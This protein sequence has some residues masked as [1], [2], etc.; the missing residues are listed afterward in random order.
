MF[1]VI[2]K[3]YDNNYA[4]AELRLIPSTDPNNY[5]VICQC[6]G[7]NDPWNTGVCTVR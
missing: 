4:Q 2:V 7:S 3:Q 5:R 6:A 1:T